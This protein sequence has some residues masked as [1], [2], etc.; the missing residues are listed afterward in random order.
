MKTPSEIR[1]TRPGRTVS[2]PT[3]EATNSSAG[4]F[5]T[6]AAGPIWT[7]RPPLITASRSPSR[8]ASVW[9]WVEATA[10]VRVS[11]RIRSRSPV[12]ASRVGGS[13]E[14]KGSSRKMISGFVTKAR[15]RLVRCAS[16]P[17]SFRAE[18]FARW[19]MPKRSRYS[20][21]V[22]SISARPTPRILSPAATFSN[23]VVSNR[24]GSWKTIAMWRR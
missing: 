15:A 8:R 18:R 14:E 7:I 13:S 2:T 5:I 17:E 24:S 10:V 19:P 22:R 1:T 12:S 3:K 6:S 9:S 11:R 16:P 21:T 20:G 23:T 4:R